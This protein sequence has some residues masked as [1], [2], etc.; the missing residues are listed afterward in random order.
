MYWKDI[1]ITFAL[2]FLVA[3][4]VIGLA[5]FGMEKKCHIQWEGSGMKSE[6]RMPGGCM[7]T[8]PDGRKIPA[9]NYREL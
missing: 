7:I 6:F 5:Y 2:I 4:C 1:A 9:A 8:L 3:A